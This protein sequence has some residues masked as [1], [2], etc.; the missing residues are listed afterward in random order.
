MIYLRSL[1]RGF[2]FEQTS[3]TTIYAD[4][5]PCIAMSHN[6]VKPEHSRHIDTRLYFLRDMVLLSL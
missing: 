6:Q 4:N 5:A 2:G 1:L 3:P